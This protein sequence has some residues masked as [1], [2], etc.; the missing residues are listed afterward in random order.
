MDSNEKKSKRPRIGVRPINS[1]SVENRS[2]FSSQEGGHEGQERHQASYGNNTY[3]NNRP[4]QPRPYN[5][6]RQGGYNNN[7]YNNQ[8]GYNLYQIDNITCR[9][10]KKYKT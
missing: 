3:G 7:R 5:N 4:Y 8:G 9:N 1:D 6:N 10:K 2:D